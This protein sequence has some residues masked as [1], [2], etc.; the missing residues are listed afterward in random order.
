M[1]PNISIWWKNKKNC[2][3]VWRVYD[4]LTES[5]LKSNHCPTAAGKESVTSGPYLPAFGMNTERYGASLCIQ[6]ECGK[7][8]TRKTPNTDTF[9]ALSEDVF[10]KKGRMIEAIPPIADGLALHTKPTIYQSSFAWGQMLEP[11]KILPTP[12]DKGWH[13]TTNSTWEPVW[14]TLVPASKRV[15]S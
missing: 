9:H 5:L 7:I 3:S 12:A 2:L 4:E 1:R 11:N 6:S 13:R 10:S 8:R 14:I 15:M